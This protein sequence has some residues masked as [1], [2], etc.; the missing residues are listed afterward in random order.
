MIRPSLAASTRSY[1]TSATSSLSKQ[2][3]ASPP[4]LAGGKK[5]SGKPE[6][7]NGLARDPK[8]P[9]PARK[10][11]IFTQYTRLVTNP[12]P[13]QPS[14]RSNLRPND[15]TAQAKTPQAITRTHPINPPNIIFIGYENL[16]VA[17]ITKVRSELSKAVDKLQ[18]ARDK[19]A[20]AKGD[21]PPEER[22]SAKFQ[23]L[24]PGLFVPVVR[25]ASGVK[26]ERKVKK[27]LKGPVAAVI[28][29]GT[30]DPPLLS[31][32]L[33]VVDKAVPPQ[34]PA[35]AFSAKKSAPSEDDWDPKPKPPPV[36]RIQ[37]I[38]AYID[39]KVLSPA[40]VKEAASLPR[41][42]EY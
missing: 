21:E 40:R 20:V 27:M 2:V 15:T 17:A 34:P 38:G 13:L 33:R 10:A 18:T 9:Y 36:P 35:P 22:L 1:A 8:R 26:E 6:A 25:N 14:E 28:M 3:S 12:V 5:I 37:V 29:H 41:S 7:K 30:L 24:R 42:Q 4:S 23:V 19:L 16:S 39:G 32:V 31:Q 11:H